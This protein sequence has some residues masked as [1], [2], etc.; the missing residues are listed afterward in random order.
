GGYSYGGRFFKCMHNHGSIT[1][2]QAIQESCNS[3]FFQVSLKLG[4]EKVI[5]WGQLFGFG[6]KTGVDLPETEE[7]PG[8]YPSEEKLLKNYK[9]WIPRGL[10][11]NYAIGQGEI[12]VTPMQMANYAAT[13]ANGGI[14]YK[15]HVVKKVYNNMVGKYEPIDIHPRNLHLDPKVM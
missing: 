9:G 15:P 6:S 14:Q 13:L 1:V 5:K 7:R 12:L 11:L 8:N 2:K 3:F 10:L 4:I